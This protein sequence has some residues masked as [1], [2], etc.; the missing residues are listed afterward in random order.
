[1]YGDSRN[2]ALNPVTIPYTYM[3]TKFKKICC[4]H[5]TTGT[6]CI[7][8]NQSI[9]M[10]W[11]TK[12]KQ[13]DYNSD[14]NDSVQKKV[15]GEKK[16]KKKMGVGIKKKLFGGKASKNGNDPHI[17]EIPKPVVVA[18]A[19][20]K[21]P[22]TPSPAKS[23]ATAR[24]VTMTPSPQSSGKSQ[25]RTP[26]TPTEGRPIILDSESDVTDYDE[27]H[28]VD[29]LNEDPNFGEPCVEMEFHNLDHRGSTQQWP[30]ETNN[31]KNK[32]KTNTDHQQTQ[33]DD[34]QF[35]PKFQ[36]EDD[37]DRD[38]QKTRKKGGINIIMKKSLGDDL[39]ASTVFTQPFS[40]KQGTS[41][42]IPKQIPQMINSLQPDIPKVIA[43]DTNNTKTPTLRDLEKDQWRKN[44]LMILT[45]ASLS[46]PFG[47]TSLPAHLA[48]KWNVE[49]GSPIWD[50]K[51]TTYK[52]PI[53]IHEDFVG[54]S[55]SNK[56]LS[57]ALPPPTATTKRS[58]RDF[59]WLEQALRNEFHGGI[60]LP[61]L[62]IL[63]GKS[64]DIEKVDRNVGFLN[65]QDLIESRKV[66]DEKILA[67]WL[68]DVLN[69]IR[70]SG[71]IL[72]KFGEGIDIFSSES[73]ESFLYR[74][75]QPH[76]SPAIPIY[77]KSYSKLI[78]ES[79]L[80][81]GEN[82]RRDGTQPISAPRQ[83]NE[84]FIKGVV[85]QSLA[86]FAP[87]QQDLDMS[88]THNNNNMIPGCMCVQPSPTRT[89]AHSP[90]NTMN[91]L[92]CTSRQ[93]V[94]TTSVLP[95]SDLS[96]ALLNSPNFTI[97]PQSSHIAIHSELIYAQTDL[98]NNYLRLSLICIRKL[99]NLLAQETQRNNA[100]K[101]F[102]I[103]LS[104][105]F[106]FEKDIETSKIGADLVD[107]EQEK[108]SS[109]GVHVKISLSKT[110]LSEG[111][112]ILTR[113]KFDRNTPS[114]RVLNGMLQAYI[115]DLHMVDPSL[116]S[117][118][119]SI[120]QISNDFS[121]EQHHQ[122]QSHAHPAQSPSTSLQQI[123]QRLK[124]QI[125]GSQ[126]ATQQ[127][128]SSSSRN[129]P[130]NRL[131]EAKILQNENLLK[132]SLTM[133]IKSV[134]LR[135]SRMAWKYFKMEANQASLLNGAAV[136]L[137]TKI[138]EGKP[139]HK[140]TS[141]R[142]SDKSRDSGATKN[143]DEIE[144]EL[145]QRILD[146]G[147]KTEFEVS[148][149]H[150]GNNN[151]DGVDE[152]ERIRV[153]SCEKAINLARE[154]VG[155][156]DSN[157]ALEIMEIAGVA[158]AEVRVEETTRDLR[159]V[160]KQAIGLRE[161]V[162]RCVEAVEALMVQVVGDVNDMVENVEVERNVK[163]SFSVSSSFEPSLIPSHHV[164]IS[165]KSR[166]EFLSILSK[167]FSGA[168]LQNSEDQHGKSTS[169]DHHENHKRSSMPSASVL[170]GVGID[171]SDPTGWLS[172]CGEDNDEAIERV[173]N[174]IPH[175][176]PITEKRGN[177][178][179]V[180]RTYYK[181]REANISSLLSRI[182][183]MLRDYEK[184]VEGI[185]SVVYMHCIG[186][187]LEKH[188]GK[189][190]AKLVAEWE[191]KTD[192]TTAINVAK[193]KKL[194]PQLL[195]ELNAKHASLENV[196]YTAVKQAKERHLASKTIKTDLI[197]LANRRFLKAKESST[198]RIL[199]IIM[200]WAQ[201]EEI[202]A[203][204]ESK[205]LGEVIREI[206]RT[207]TEKDIIADGGAHLFAAAGMHSSPCQF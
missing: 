82:S 149:T 70:G 122:Q 173:I 159:L 24:T 39:T 105:L 135:M 79:H 126:N 205:S 20:K 163:R 51:E 146:L 119:D 158:D 58:L 66:V 193:R 12:S 55:D 74:T 57:S 43:N 110:T 5:T 165:M 134:P 101:R 73:M 166:R 140:A 160:R 179:R 115:T 117:H 16:S 8:T 88:T 138:S 87:V 131:V 27:E 186:I 103:A 54:S 151:N 164:P 96:V 162:E 143:D 182:S 167:V 198:E 106:S 114:L 60:L 80:A 32:N 40:P 181:V 26:T 172:A 90:L 95:D 203:L 44:Q 147:K 108:E 6:C 113:Q 15:E 176:V 112:R 64:S 152:Y 29:I 136:S 100:W 23:T 116:L 1:M 206:E 183:M 148:T 78:R 99:R 93:Q 34:N 170:S 177:C 175:N 46:R 53:S 91:M 118:M 132:K 62:S 85:K 137:R 197:N 161:K 141:R 157:L 28:N 19:S 199:D 9:E 33:Q 194:S 72:M 94:P 169:R 144:I 191:K 63:L 102:A 195:E 139:R 67:E 189:N 4:S 41:V 121:D 184:R 76:N 89:G 109:R 61:L 86:C 129:S 196:S 104:N 35:I 84:S 128:F 83:K 3:C 187:Q 178:G 156:W 17:G 48:K 30:E 107:S 97:L 174:N 171:P 190:R 207:M 168:I 68:S 25:S 52:Y 185:E 18:V 150:N 130:H 7:Q 145:I 180:A 71:E 188:F 154:R 77:R 69:G 200:L 75:N 65:I 155:R 13:K 47:R 10:P 125:A 120:S 142:K 192:I 111:L 31:N 37:S 133:L 153:A 59:V 14:N 56:K 11:K 202:I 2:Q 49:I 21:I 201:Y 36:F 45:R 124:Q 22:A 98:I 42:Y 123:G 81:L 50:E 38:G 92:N 204:E 127:S